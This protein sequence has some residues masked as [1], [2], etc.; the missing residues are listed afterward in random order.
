MTRRICWLTYSSLCVV[1]FFTNSAIAQKVTNPTNEHPNPYRTINGYFDLPGGRPWGST[2]AVDIDIDG[3]SIWVA[4]RCG[5]NSCATSNV[6][7]V[8]KYEAYPFL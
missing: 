6:D 4:E 5:T 7:S 8:I 1:F 2:S 3:E